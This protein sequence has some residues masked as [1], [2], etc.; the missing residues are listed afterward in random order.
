MEHLYEFMPWSHNEPETV[1]KKQS[2]LD[3]WLEEYLNNKD[4]PVLVYKDKKQIAGAGLHNRLN[5]NA[6]EID[7]WVRADEINKGIATKLSLALTIVALQFIKVDAV[8][9]RHDIKNVVSSKI[10]LKL[11]Y[12]N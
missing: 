2:R 6:L 12:K 4:Y 8:E 1:E 11:K 7:Y 3:V 5:R 10:P 9:I